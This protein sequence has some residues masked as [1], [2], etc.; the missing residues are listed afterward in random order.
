M[1]LNWDTGQSELGIE[2]GG[3]EIWDEI[4][5]IEKL[6]LWA[7]TIPIAPKLET[8]KGQAAKWQ[9]AEYQ[10]EEDLVEGEEYQAEVGRWRDQQGV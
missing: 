8:A 4:G 6:I 1:K 5:G 3:F 10:A 2:T 9:A 7:V